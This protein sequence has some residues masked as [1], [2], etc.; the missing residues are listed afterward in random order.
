MMT[1]TRHHIPRLGL[2]GGIGSGKS[3]ALAYL[4]ELRR[5]R[6][7]ER[8]HRARAATTSLT[9]VDR[10]RGALRRTRSSTAPAASTGRRWPRIVFA[11]RGR[12]RWLEDLLHPHVRAGRRR[13]GRGAAEGAAAA[14]APRGGGAAAVRDRLG[15]AFDFIMLITAPDDVRRRRLSGQAHRQRVRAAACAQQ[16]PEEEKIARS[17]FVFDNTGARKELR[18]FVGQTVAHDPRRRATPPRGTAPARA[19][20]EAPA[21]LVVLVAGRRW[22]ASLGVA[23]GRAALV[24]GVRRRPGTRAPST[25]SSTPAPSAPRRAA[26]TSTRRWWRPSSTPRAASTST[27]ARRRAPSASCRCCPRPPSRSR[28]ETGGVRLRARRPRG[29]ARQR[30]LR[31][32]TTCARVL[33]RFDGDVRRG[34][35]R[36]QRRR[37]RGGGVGGRGRAPRV[38]PL[39]VADIPYAETRAYVKQVLRRARIYREKYGERLARPQGRREPR[40]ALACERVF[41]LVESTAM[42]DFTIQADYEPHRR[43]ARGRRRARRRRRC[44]ATATRRCSASPARARPSPWPTSSQKVQKPTLVIA[45]NKTLA[46]QLCNEFR[47]FLPDNAVEYFVSYYDYYQPEAYVPAQ[48]LYIEKDSS[49]NDEIDRLRHAATTSLFLRRDVVIVA[50]VSCIYGLGSPED[51]LEKM[52]AAAGRRQPSTATRCCASSSTS[53]TRATT[54]SSARGKFRVRGDSIEIWPAAAGH[55]HPRAVLGRRG[56]ADRQLRPGRRRGPREAASTSPSTRPRTSS[57]TARPSSAPSSRSGARS[58]SAAPGSTRA[59]STAGLLVTK[60]VAG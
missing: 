13:L 4:H 26:T 47:E 9:I 45:H 1:D 10:I 8:R 34:R 60:C 27:R 25:R 17:D 11:R 41:V 56:R 7:L 21:S 31:H 37:R 12:A 52:V 33:D 6:D 51:Y 29:P 18:E 40:A 43:P 38:T 28:D 48:D 32:A 2:T 54:S 16:M 35:R 5:R 55:G 59:R 36:L 24:G 46:A 50:S 49:I 44:A 58:T 14:R 23:S 15:A 22:P 57:P 53:S 30:P 42:N 20:R 3:T 19:R 39:R